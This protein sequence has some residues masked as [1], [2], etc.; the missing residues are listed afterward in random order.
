MVISLVSRWVSKEGPASSVSR[1]H[2][3]VVAFHRKHVRAW[4]MHKGRIE[5]GTSQSRKCSVYQRLY[6]VHSTRDRIPRNTFGPPP[7]PPPP[8][9]AAEF[10]DGPAPSPMPGHVSLPTRRPESE[11]WWTV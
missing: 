2:R 9:L 10:E 3:G 7:P 5:G 4:A 8:P 1:T 11:C 6:T